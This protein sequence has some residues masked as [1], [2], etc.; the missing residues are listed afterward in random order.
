MKYLAENNHKV[1]VEV[2][3]RSLDEVRQV[4]ALNK[5]KKRVDRVMLD[6]F[7][8]KNDDGELLLLHDVYVYGSIPNL[9]LCLSSI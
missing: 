4:L 7:V 6:N 9:R 2:E 3:T 5:E 8:T 1:P